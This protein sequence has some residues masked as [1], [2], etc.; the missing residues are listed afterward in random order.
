M[1][2]VSN[3]VTIMGKLDDNNY[4]AGVQGQVVE[5]VQGDDHNGD[6]CVKIGLK[7]QY[8]L[9][10]CMTDE[11]KIIRFNKDELQKDD[12]WT[13]ENKAL[14]LYGSNYWHHI[15]YF[16]EP[17]NP[18]KLC[19]REDCPNQRTSRI[20]VNIW[21]TVCEYDVC[22]KCKEDWHGKCCDEFPVRKT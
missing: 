21:G 1:I 20:M 8:L 7:H 4:W 17:L 22:D 15:R 6:V 9:G 18:D 13:P 5:I 3:I 16:T 12:D 19:M 11:E 10:H 2:E 14:M